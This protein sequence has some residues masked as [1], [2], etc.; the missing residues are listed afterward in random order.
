[1]LRGFLTFSQVSLTELYS[2]WCGLKDLFTL[3]KLADKV[4]LDHQK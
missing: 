1:M 2:L 4:V 3:L